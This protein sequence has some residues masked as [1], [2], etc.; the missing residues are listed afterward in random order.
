MGVLE[1]DL[2]TQQEIAQ[3]LNKSLSN[4]PIVAERGT[5]EMLEDSHAFTDLKRE[6]T[7]SRGGS[8]TTGG[9]VSSNVLEPL[10]EIDELDETGSASDEQTEK[11]KIT[12]LEEILEANDDDDEED[13][14]DLPVSANA[15]F[16]SG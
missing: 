4:L 9:E 8:I 15:T 16:Q 11:V 7:L 12:N 14:N 5:D 3:T 2:K 13:G 6:G 10:T 1:L